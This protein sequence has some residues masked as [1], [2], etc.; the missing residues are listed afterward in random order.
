MKYL[1]TRKIFENQE[2]LNRQSPL[3]KLED[4]VDIEL[5]EKIQ[6]LISSGN[7]LEISCGNGADALE[8][9]KRGYVVFGTENNQQYADHVNQKINCVKHD[10]RNKFPFPD[11]SFDLVYSRLGLHYFS[12]SE[13]QSI[14]KEI[15]RI[16]KE[17]LV[18]TVKLVNDIKTG[19][20]IFDKETW[21]NLVSEEFK[22]VSSEVKEGIL[23][24][25]QSKW[26]EMVARK[27]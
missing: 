11:N 18:F 20:T 21:E 24:D 27:I 17:Y 15:S 22:I 4:N 13:L 23:Y 3:L 10:T 6:S 9:L 14:F 5:I 2:E 25:N 16:T 26:L 8:L 12:E 7:I 19:K 1:L